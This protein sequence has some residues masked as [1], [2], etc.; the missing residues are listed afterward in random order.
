MKM[1]RIFNRLVDLGLS[2]WIVIDWLY[3]YPG[4]SHKKIN[5]AAPLTDKGQ[6][7]WFRKV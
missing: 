4:L 3:S 6:L 7:L 2:H 5:V 1:S